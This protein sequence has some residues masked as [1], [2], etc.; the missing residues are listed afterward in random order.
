MVYDKKNSVQTGL[1]AKTD[2]TKIPV[3]VT[4]LLNLMEELV[5][6]MVQENDLVLTRDTH[7][8]AQLLLRKQRLTVD[9]RSSMKLLQNQPEVLETLPED[10]RQSL[11]TL[12]TKLSDVSERNAKTLRSAITATQRLLQ[13]VIAMIKMEALPKLSYKNPQTAHLELGSFSP[14]CKA[15]SVSTT[16]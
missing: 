2:P 10:V 6:V 7:E 8:H 12:S 5:Q 3:F 4:A 14:T 13:N 9:Y 1:K 11:R 15:V 16:A